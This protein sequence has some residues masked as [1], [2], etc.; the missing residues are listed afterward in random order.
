MS[1]IENCK[2]LIDNRIVAICLHG[3][4][5][6]ELEKRIY[7]FQDFNIC[8]TSVG[9]WELI[10]NHILSKINKELE[11]TFDTAEVEKP[12]RFEILRRIP[13]LKEYLSRSTNNFHITMRHLSISGLR[14][15][16]GCSIEKDYASKIIYSEDI[17]PAYAFCVSFPLFITSLWALGAKKIILFGCDGSRENSINTY[18]HPEEVAIEKKIADNE[19]FN[20]SGD[21]GWVAGG[22]PRII[23][24][25]SRDTG[26]KPPEVINCSLK[27]IH[28]LYPIMSYD[29][30]IEWIKQNGV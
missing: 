3:N 17:C 30:T 7:E 2:K 5:I 21:C 26:M 15:K 23:E 22:F 27:S 18:F 29:Q 24:S 12:I 10:E 9:Q 6:E 16:I 28:T 8:W 4:S 19:T 25:F 1:A 14:E 11:I 20:L 13:R